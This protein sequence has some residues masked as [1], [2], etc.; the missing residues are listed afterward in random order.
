M[1]KRN[2]MNALALRNQFIL[3]EDPT[4]IICTFIDF[5]ISIIYL[6]YH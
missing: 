6:F 2:G 1:N 4:R 3:T 5:I